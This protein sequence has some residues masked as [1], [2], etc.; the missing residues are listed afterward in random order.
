MNDEKKQKNIFV[1]L[2]ILYKKLYRESIYR[3]HIV[4]HTERRAD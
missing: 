1:I 2:L 3:S 4:V